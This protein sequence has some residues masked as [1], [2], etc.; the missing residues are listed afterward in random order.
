MTNDLKF[1]N[2]HQDKYRSVYNNG[3]EF[4][5]EIIVIELL[6]LIKIFAN[7]NLKKEVDKILERTNHDNK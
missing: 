4:E 2:K 3:C 1:Y 7:D 5:K 6:K